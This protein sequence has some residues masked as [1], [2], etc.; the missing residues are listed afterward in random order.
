[1]ASA[2]DA[3]KLSKLVRLCQPPL[4]EERFIRVATKA[5]LSVMKMSEVLSAVLTCVAFLVSLLLFIVATKP[6]RRME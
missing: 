4:Q 2:K 1:M 6:R 5:F 3:D